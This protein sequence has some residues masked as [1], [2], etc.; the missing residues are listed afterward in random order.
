VDDN[1]A[2][3]CRCGATWK[4]NTHKRTRKDLKC[5]SCRMHRALV[6]K[7]G[8]EKCIPWQGDFDKATLSIPIFD[9]KPVLPGIRTCGHS[10]CTN[11]NHVA[12]DH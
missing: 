8:S 3:C 5:Q 9:G 4:V 10:D 1:V 11:P 6:I 12:G 2:L 7:Y